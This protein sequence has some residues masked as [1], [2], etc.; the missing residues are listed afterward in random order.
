ME[1]VDYRVRRFADYGGVC[2]RRTPETL[3][4]AARRDNPKGEAEG[5][6]TALR[7][8]L[9]RLCGQLRSF[10]L[11][12]DRNGF[13]TVTLLNCWPCG[14]SSLQRASQPASM[15]AATISAS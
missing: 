6:V 9:P 2:P 14:R 7:G 1:L 15:A 11:H 10:S 5:Q 3:A 4:T 12:Y 13:T 8:V